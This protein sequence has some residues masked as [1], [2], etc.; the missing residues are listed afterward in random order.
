[1]KIRCHTK[2]SGLSILWVSFLI[3]T[4]AA[5]TGCIDDH[6]ASIVKSYPMTIK[7]D[8]Q[9][10]L[11]WDDIA[12]VKL[13]ITNDKGMND[14][15]PVTGD[16]NLNL[17][18]G[19]YNMTVTG[20]VKDE[21][22]AYVSGKGQDVLFGETT[23]QL[24]LH[25]ILQSPF[26]F[27]E[28]YC[29]GGKKGYTKD[30]YFEIVNNSDEVQY[31]DGVFISAPLGVQTM[32]NAWQSAGITDL[33]SCGQGSVVAFP[34]TGH[35]YPLRPG[36]SVVI[37]ND[38]TN[39]SV[40]AGDGNHCPDLSNAPWEVYFNT[41]TKDM[42]YP[43]AKNLDIIFTNQPTGFLFGLGV[44]G[45]AFILGKVPEGKTLTDFVNDPQYLQTTPNS[46]SKTIYL[47]TPSKYVL[48]AVDIWD[49]TKST[50]YGVFSPK[51]DA[52]GIIGPPSYSGLCVRRKV[53]SI[54]N[55]RPYY[56]DTNNSSHDFLSNQPLTPGIA[57]TTV[58]E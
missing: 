19:Q 24:T 47:M 29:F 39:H 44:F 28:L 8:L 23:T 20:R 12:D 30:M 11:V 34:G 48:D 54:E 1:M 31:L 26:L 37:A 56:V 36:E 7:F 25:K 51:D 6:N 2:K 14:T 22:A 41:S 46:T 27:K 57:P 55:G 15:L 4:I 50:H 17:I 21:T 58:D 16:M 13:I 52:E 32:P 18:Q 49:G 43:N 35:D 40:D 33:Y 10:N 9:D 45:H 3:I 5:L 38:A 53:K 42:D